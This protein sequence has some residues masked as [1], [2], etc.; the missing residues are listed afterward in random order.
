MG[1]S[2]F[3]LL[4]S[5]PC[6]CFQMEINPVMI[7]NCLVARAVRRIKQKTLTLCVALVTCVQ[8]A[9]GDHKALLLLGS[10]EYRVFMY[11]LSLLCFL[12]L[13]LIDSI[14]NQLHSQ[15]PTPLLSA[16]PQI[17]TYESAT[18]QTTLKVGA[19]S[20]VNTEEASFSPHVLGVSH[21]CQVK[22][23]EAKGE[24]GKHANKDLLG[25]PEGKKKIIIMGVGSDKLTVSS[26]LSA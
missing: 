6:S 24:K 18:D 25:K 14:G 21:L 8:L 9:G 12:L 10:G 4:L 15:G 26:S 22:Q 3:H 13:S 20:Q 19:L 11:A 1:T 17:S 7:F 23:L 5:L 16:L 2:L